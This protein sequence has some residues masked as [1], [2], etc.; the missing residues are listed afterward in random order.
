MKKINIVHFHNFHLVCSFN[1][2]A[3]IFLNKGKNGILFNSNYSNFVAPDITFYFDVL[4]DFFLIYGSF[5]GIDKVRNK[6]HIVEKSPVC[7]RNEVLVL[8]E[9]RIKLGTKLQTHFNYFIVFRPFSV[10]PFNS[11]IP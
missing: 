6:R 8:V 4:V 9:V 7:I 2:P 3:N 10:T 1:F 5:V 11:I